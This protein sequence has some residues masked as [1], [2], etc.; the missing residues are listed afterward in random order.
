M[1]PGLLYELPFT[2]LHPE[3]VDGVFENDDADQI[4]WLVRSFN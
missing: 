4:V 3:G 2:D 1:D